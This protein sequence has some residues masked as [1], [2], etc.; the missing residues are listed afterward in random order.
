[1][2]VAVTGAAGRIGREVLRE[3]REHGGHE[4]WALDRLLPPS[5]AA[6]RAL[7]VDLADAGQV[8]G[9]LAGVDAVVH[10]GAFPSEAHHPGEL[11]YVN[12]TAAC[13][14][15]A[16]ACAAYGI[17]KLV[18]TSSITVYSL[19]VQARGGGIST[20]P[21]DETLPARPDEWYPLSKWV[22][23]EIFTTKAREHGIH[24]ASLRPALVVGPD[25]YAQRGQPRHDRD[26]SGGL[27]AYVDSRDVALMA[28]LALEKLDDLGPGNHVFNCGAADA[29]SAQPLSEVIPRFLPELREAARTLTGN[30]PA[31]SIEKA[32]RVLGY[33]PRYSWRDHVPR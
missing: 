14:H 9:A 20:L 31:F 16:A 29:H 13:A 10:M 6:Q 25:E 5:G 33:T 18:Y 3:L 26:A 23:E 4:V 2:K 7:Y 27:W 15:V 22:G 28:R 24:V 1:M 11:V 8:Y 12:N 17:R 21:V 30:T 19:D 32:Q